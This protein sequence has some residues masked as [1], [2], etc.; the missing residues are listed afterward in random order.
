MTLQ[1][2]LQCIRPLDIQAMEAAQRKL[3]ALCKP[4]G[5]L[6]RL[7]QHLVKIAGITASSHIPLQKKAVVV[8]CADNGV[9]AQGVTQ[10]GQEVTAMVAENMAV[11]DTCLCAMARVAK[12]DVI[13]VDIGVS[14]DISPEIPRIV[15]RKIAYGTADFSKG[16]AMTTEQ[17][18]AAIEVGISLAKELSQQ[19][20]TLLATGEMGIGNTV[21]SAAMASAMLGLPPKGTCG[22]G[23][24]LS[25]EGLARK[26]QVVEEALQQHRPNPQD[27]MD[28][29]TKL[30]G[31]DIA[32]MMGLCIGGA[33][34]RVPV[35]L[36]GLISCVAALAAY[37]LCP[38]VKEY[39]LPS[40]LSPEPAAMPI[41]DHLGLQPLLHGEMR[42]GEG[43]GALATFPLYDMMVTVYNE[44]VTFEQEG[45]EAYIPQEKQVEMR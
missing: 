32:G 29:L 1:Q 14:R 7:E 23:S 36:D 38:L 33:A 34:Y 11:G 31:L 22:R 18:T 2:A 10:T 30:G 41:L 15:R 20:Y 40:H 28:V 35:V 42:L 25:D 21:T 6:G 9:V 19:G 26:I 16:P 24:G 12:V 13:P 17:A 8:F 27:A 44:M 45:M 4:L 3:D 39:L 5:S 37:R 43:S